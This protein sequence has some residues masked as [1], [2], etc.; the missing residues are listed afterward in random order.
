MRAEAAH[1]S[2]L[3][4]PASRPARRWSD[5]RMRVRSKS[6]AV[7]VDRDEHRAARAPTSQ[8]PQDEKSGRRRTSRIEATVLHDLDE[9]EQP[10]LVGPHATTKMTAV[11][12]MF[13][14]GRRDQ[15]LPAEVHEL[16]VSVSRQRPPH[17]HHDV[18]E[19]EDLGRK[20]P[21]R[22]QRED[23]RVRGGRRVGCPR[24][25][26]RPSPSPETTTRRERRSRRSQT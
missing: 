23:D 10:A 22:Q 18:D 19:R 9:A 5:P 7:P 25:R 6:E 4:R 11:T 1:L 24:R 12:T 8:R 20:D 26:R 16:I 15:P 2:P 17:P 21:D 13:D 3:R 14:E